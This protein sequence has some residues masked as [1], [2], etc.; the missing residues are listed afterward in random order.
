[1]RF[2]YYFGNLNGMR[3][4]PYWQLETYGSA[5]VI[6]SKLLKVFFIVACFFTIG[7]NWLIPIFVNKIRDVKIRYGG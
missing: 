2:I 4:N 3:I 7:T 5:F 6:D 1:M